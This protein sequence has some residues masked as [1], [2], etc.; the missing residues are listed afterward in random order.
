M[1]KFESYYTIAQ[2]LAKHLQGELNS[3]ES[4]QLEE[5]LQADVRN[6]ELLQKLTDE[7]SLESEFRDYAAVDEISGWKQLADTIDRDA[8]RTGKINLRRFLPYAAAILLACTAGI[9]ALIH[10]THQEPPAFSVARPHDILPGTNKAV[11]TLANGTKVVLTDEKVKMV[12]RQRNMLIRNSGGGTLTYLQES[13][14]LPPVKIEPVVMMNTLTTPAGGQYHLV[15]PDGTGVWLNAASSLTYPVAFNGNE[16]RVQL[17]GEGYFEVSK[18]AARPF[19]VKTYA[20]TVQVLGTH[21]NVNAYV[22]ENETKTTLLEGSVSV[23]NSAHKQVKLSPGQQ[24]VCTTS[25]AGIIRNA[26]MDEAVAWKNGKFLFRNTELHAI[27][28]QLSRWYGV[29]VKFQGAIAERHYRGKI[30][31]NVP[32]S[33][34]FDILKSSGINFII[35]G[36][37]IIVKS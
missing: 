7:K 10:F 1:D 37:K 19:Y 11:L 17:K 13:A 25:S 18:D 29:D 22:D 6:R 21:F 5:W 14:A 12:A 4:R 33:Q 26:D 30:S 32:V 27:M 3:A 15:L 28:R 2:L 23:Q 35:N 16:R 34:V 9:A 20:Q 31:R 8:V 24:A 36:K